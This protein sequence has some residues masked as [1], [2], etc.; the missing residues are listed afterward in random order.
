M[1]ADKPKLS[2]KIGNVSQVTISLQFPVMN[3]IFQLNKQSFI[4]KKRK[5]RESFHLALYSKSECYIN[6]LHV[7]YIFELVVVPHWPFGA[8]NSFK[9]V[10]VDGHKAQF[11][12][13]LLEL[14]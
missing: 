7:F 2:P 13:N 4:K 6:A 1:I 3:T 10:L 5:K 8:K 12:F 11:R 14:S 9:S